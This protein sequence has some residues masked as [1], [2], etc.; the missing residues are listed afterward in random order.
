MFK[1]RRDAGQKLAQALGKFKNT[2]PLVLAIPRGGV[3]V[4][5]QVARCLCADFSI[6][7]SRKLPFPDNPEAGFGAVAE[8]GTTFIMPGATR[9][10]IK[11][12]I[13]HIIEEQKHETKRRIDVLRKGAPL[14]EIA[15]RILILVD[16]GIAMGSTMRVSI[17]MA[18]KQRAKRIIVAVP[19]T[20][21]DTAVDIERIVDEI[22]VLEKPP[23]FHAVAQV[24]ENWHDVSDEE[25]LN[26]LSDWEKKNN[27]PKNNAG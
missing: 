5:Y 18:R 11:S 7:V 19:V 14:P 12:E 22:I 24:Y 17:E 15:D 27:P 26:I 10:L 1:D 13:E 4:G 6:I 21:A 9:W 23:W 16:D 2:D 20:G 3:E 8:D 25:V